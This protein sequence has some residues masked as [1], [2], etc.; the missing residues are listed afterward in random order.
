MMSIFRTEDPA[1][2]QHLLKLGLNPGPV[3]NSVVHDPAQFGDVAEACQ[4][5]YA[6]N[7]RTALRRSMGREG[8][9]VRT[10]EQLLRALTNGD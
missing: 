5:F 8:V 4:E 2:A 6:R 3:R 10:A 7:P 1:L 9:V